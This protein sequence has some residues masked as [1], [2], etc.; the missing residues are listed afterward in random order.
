[1]LLIM[2]NA[3]LTKYIGDGPVFP[4]DGFDPT[5]KTE[6]WKNLLYINNFWTVEKMVNYFELRTF[7]HNFVN[8]L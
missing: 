3:N 4:I 6:W 7:F 2:I 1:M 8:P 5:C